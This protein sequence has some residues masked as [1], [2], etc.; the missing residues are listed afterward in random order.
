[1]ANQT[2]SI[3]MLSLERGKGV[4]HS[5]MFHN[6]LGRGGVGGRG[7][8]TNRT[9]KKLLNYSCFSLLGDFSTNT[10]HWYFSACLFG[11]LQLDAVARFCG[12]LSRFIL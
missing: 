12:S 4:L 3:L 2:F 8:K 5:T 6:I 9:P 10:K 11:F 1:M 7:A